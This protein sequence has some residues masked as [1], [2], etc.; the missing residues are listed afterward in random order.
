M[1]P[2]G[3]PAPE[4]FPHQFRISR[5]PFADHKKRGASL[6]AI[7]QA[8]DHSG[9]ARVGPV[10]DRQPD[11]LP[12]RFEMGPHAHETLGGRSEQ[13]IAEIEIRPYEKHHRRYGKKWERGDGDEFAEDERNE[14]WRHRRTD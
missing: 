9:G 10:I 1:V 6:M 13:V 2:D 12:G 8:E 3:V 7:E 4:N 5:H 11:F 14:H